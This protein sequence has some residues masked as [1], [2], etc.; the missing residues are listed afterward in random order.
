MSFIEFF[1]HEVFCEYEKSKQCI[2]DKDLKAAR[3]KVEDGINND[4]TAIF[5]PI[6]LSTLMNQQVFKRDV[7]DQDVRERLVEASFRAT[8]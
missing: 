7:M 6:F 3:H 4:P 5:H 8:H 2:F 1:E